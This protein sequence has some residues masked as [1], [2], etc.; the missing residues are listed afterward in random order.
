M[1]YRSGFAY[2]YRFTLLLYIRVDLLSLLPTVNICVHN[3]VS[4][5]VIFRAI[6]VT[7]GDV[8]AL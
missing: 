5:E 4:V 6:Y 7:F 3:N 8:T 2:R 1:Q